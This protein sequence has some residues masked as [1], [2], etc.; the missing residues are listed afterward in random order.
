MISG[1]SGA[2]LGYRD[3]LDLSSTGRRFFNVLQYLFFIASA[4]LPGSASL[5]F[6]QFPPN[7]RCMSKIRLSSSS[8]HYMRLLGFFRLIYCFS[9]SSGVRSGKYSDIF[10]QSFLCTLASLVNSLHSSYVHFPLPDILELL[11][12]DGSSSKI[13]IGVSQFS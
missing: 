6:F 8:V 10:S 1:K 2:S 13:L 9:S 7:L 11:T 3:L 5:I 12:V 4:G